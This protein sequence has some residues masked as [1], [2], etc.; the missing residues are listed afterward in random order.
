VPPISAGSIA[1]LAPQARFV[2][3]HSG[4]FIK[5]D[6]PDAVVAAK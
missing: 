4:H 3:V 5:N 1:G 6:Q 2:L